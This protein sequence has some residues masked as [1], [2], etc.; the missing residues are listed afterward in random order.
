MNNQL[1]KLWILG[2]PFAILVSAFVYYAMFPSMRTWVDARSPWIRDHIGSRLPP[3]DDD[4]GGRESAAQANARRREAEERA[5]AAQ[6]MPPSPVATPKP[7][8]VGPDGAVDLSRLAGDRAA[9]PKTVRLKAA[10]EFPAVVN[11]KKVGT[12]AAPA[13]SEASLVAIQAGKLGVEFKGGGA[14]VDP[15]ETDLPVRLRDAA[16]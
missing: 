12:I 6:T 8:F 3:R 4:S 11:G 14:W 10:R 9:W 13:G 2:P 15:A 7:S 1:S 16:R 5:A